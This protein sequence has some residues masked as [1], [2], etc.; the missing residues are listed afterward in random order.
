MTDDNNIFKVVTGGKDADTKIKENEYLVI[1]ID[2]V[3]YPVTGFLIFTSQHV[4]VMHDDGDGAIPALVIPLNRLKSAELL[5]DD[6]DED[7]VPF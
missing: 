4:A 3:K 1:D 6:E 7:G 2:N 5:E